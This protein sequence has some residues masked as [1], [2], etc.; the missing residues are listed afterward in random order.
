MTT[1]NQLPAR[2]RRQGS[3]DL[4]VP[5]AQTFDLFTAQ[6][7]RGWV[8]GWEPVILSSCGALEA[9]AV[10]LTSLGGEE[11]IWTVI[12]AD[13][14]DRRLH[15]S[16]V[17]PGRR[18]GLVEVRITPHGEGSRIHVAYDLT[19]LGPDGEAVVAAMD[20]RGFAA[21]LDEWKRM[22]DRAN[23]GPS[24]AEAKLENVQ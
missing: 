17:S 1:I 8:P 24:P 13:R 21:M 19:A 11:T 2:S 3:F 16:R 20:E 23:G 7:E 9:G 14:T 4:A 15:Y 18:A 12:A 6:G 22:I 5:A 10:F